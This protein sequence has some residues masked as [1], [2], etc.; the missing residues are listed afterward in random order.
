MWWTELVKKIEQGSEG[1]S[2][3]FPG[4]QTVGENRS[5]NE[6]TDITFLCVLPSK[7]YSV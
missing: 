6:S 3:S 5:I 2:P 4:K 1:S 7:A